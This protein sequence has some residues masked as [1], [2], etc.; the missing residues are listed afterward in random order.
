[1]KKLNEKEIN[2]F[3]KKYLP[4]WF[5]EIKEVNMLTY[6]LTKEYLVNDHYL[7]V[8]KPFKIIHKDLQES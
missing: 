4:E 7:V 2:D 1:M 5:G 8:V 6:K 3:T